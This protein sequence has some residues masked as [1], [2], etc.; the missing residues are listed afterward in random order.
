M[1]T[2]TPAQIMAAYNNAKILCE[3]AY[4]GQ[5]VPQKDGSF[6]SICWISRVDRA[7]TLLAD[8]DKETQ[9]KLI[10]PLER[11][12]IKAITAAEVAIME[13]VEL[14][15]QG[16]RKPQSPYPPGICDCDECRKKDQAFAIAIAKKLNIQEYVK[17]AKREALQEMQVAA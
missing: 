7:Y 14:C 9:E 1:N 16:D 4:R 2:I 8:K 3:Q 10:G 13:Y 15:K 6:L 12:A 17:Q 5:P 11:D